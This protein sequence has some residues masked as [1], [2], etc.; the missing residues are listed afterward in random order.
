MLLDLQLRRVVVL[1]G[2]P[3][4]LTG[5]SEAL[6]PLVSNASETSACVLFSLPLPIIWLTKLS[7]IE[8]LPLLRKVSCILLNVWLQ[9]FIT[10]F[11]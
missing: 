4:L 6:T 7:R 1:I 2:P 9:Q 3:G 5:R 11:F 10:T 8:D